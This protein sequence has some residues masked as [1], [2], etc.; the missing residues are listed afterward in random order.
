MAKSARALAV[1]ILG[2]CTSAEQ[3]SNL[4]LDTAIKRNDLA[5]TDRAL[6][7]ALVYGVI[8]KKLTLEYHISVLAKRPIGEIAPAVRILLSV[9]LY[10]LA[11][12]DR[13]PTHA[14]VNE[15]VEL[16]PKRAKGFVNAIMR[17]YCRAEGKI[18]LPDREQDLIRFLSVKYSFD[19][20]VCARFV[21]EFGAERAEALLASFGVQPPLTLRVNT[22]KITREE[23]LERLAEQ[24][25]DAM[26]TK[27]SRTGILVR[28]N[29]P[30]RELYGFAEGL[31]FVQDEASQLCTEAVGAEAGMTVLDLCACPGS[32]SFGIALDMKNEGRVCSCDLHENKLSLVRDGAARL[33]ISIVETYARDA[34]NTREEWIGRADRVLCDVPCSGFGVFAKK[35]ELRYKDPERSRDLPAIQTNIL[36]TAAGYVKRGGRLIYSTCTLLPQENEENVERFLREH[37][38]F[39]LVRERTL[40]PLEDGTDGFYFAVLE[41][42]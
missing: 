16:A 21:E 35:P 9:G 18:E 1:E 25:F 27:E 14:A 32:K 29:A 15:T 12:M 40:T 30:V 37:P 38:D 41:R 34:R 8:E 33:G 24:G 11:Y 13:I 6:L 26:P 39:T 5:A 23:L 22:L 17:A 19:E 2:R 31:F 10:Q 42:N 28:G 3:Y 20:R 4:A 36:R 7:T